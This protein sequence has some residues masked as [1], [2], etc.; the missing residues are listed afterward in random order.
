M[1]NTYRALTSVVALAALM[2]AVPIGLAAASVR[3]FGTANPLHGV[4]APWRWI[5]DGTAGRIATEPLDDDAIVDVI[6]RLGLVSVWVALVVVVVTTLAETLHLLR[7]RGFSLPSVR[8]LGW[9]QR[10]GRFIAAGLIMIGPITL[11]RGSHAAPPLAAPAAIAMTLD[12]AATVATVPRLHRGMTNNDGVPAADQRTAN[13]VTTGHLTTGRIGDR[14]RQAAP[15]APDDSLDVDRHVVARGESVYSIAARLAGGDPALT[16]QIADAIL[17][18][19]LGMLMPDGQRFTTPAYIEPGWVLVLPGPAESPLDAPPL[20]LTPMATQHIVETGD[21]LSSIAAEHL[22][23]AVE[24]HEIWDENAGQEMTDGRVFDD[25]DLILPGWQ[26][27]LPAAATTGVQSS[28]A[29]A[30]SD[31]PAST[32]Q[33]SASHPVPIDASGPID[34]S[35]PID[36][37]GRGPA[38]K[39]LDAPPGSS[40]LAAP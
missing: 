13:R 24:W 34:T 19:N 17:D 32:V 16:V 28:P 26:L 7:H 5:D 25:P 6:V 40:D 22:G 2:V 35:V 27:D 18:T 11:A 33:N 3:R 1:R 10:A 12:D 8:G 36:A 23:G 21:T 39:N 9:A 15:P 31:Q 30:A 38:E 29:P 14:P 20:D 37:S 4:T